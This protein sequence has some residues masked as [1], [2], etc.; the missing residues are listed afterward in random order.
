[1]VLEECLVADK[2]ESPTNMLE[3]SL[4]AGKEK[5]MTGK[6]ESPTD[7]EDSSTNTLNISSKKPGKKNQNG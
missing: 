2:E 4:V 6:E 3:E 5:F 7:L 1:M